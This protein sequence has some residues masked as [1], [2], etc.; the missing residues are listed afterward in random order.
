[1]S[2]TNETYIQKLIKQK[3][4]SEPFFSTEQ[5]ASHTVLEVDHFPY[6]KFFKGDYTSDQPTVMNREA[7]V[8]FQKKESN[9]KIKKPPMEVKPNHCFHYPCTT[10]RPCYVPISGRYKNDLMI[11]QYINTQQCN[12]RYR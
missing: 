3:Q 8:S 10:V 1:M 7:G 5:D 9:T 6:T 11:N 4:S 2:T 12:V